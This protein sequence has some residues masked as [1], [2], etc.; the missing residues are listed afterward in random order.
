M[1]GIAALKNA[2][3]GCD[4]WVIA[5]GPSAG[6]VDP[7]FF[8]GK[9]TVCV[10]FT[11]QTFPASY[12]MVK[13][14]YALQAALDAGEIVVASRF[15]CGSRS[16]VENLSLVSKAETQPVYIF[17]HLENRLDIV[18]LSVIG[19]D[20]QLVVSFS[21]ITSALHLAAYLGAANIILVGHDCGTVDGQLKMPAYYESDFQVKEPGFYRRF[22][23]SIEP[24]TL[25]VRD[26]IRQVYG[27]RV[28]SL[29]PWVNLGMEGHSYER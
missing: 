9:I 26:R 16:H 7:E 29:N 19:S 25:A 10:N 14:G 3:A 18:D 13:E 2:H 24:Q 11:W 5:A 8:H 28:Y 21:T 15:H 1:A 6:F 12:V 22:I 17:D 4:I 20:N 27:A 23:G